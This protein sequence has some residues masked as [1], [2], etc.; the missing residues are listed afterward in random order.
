MSG[1]PSLLTAGEMKAVK[2]EKL[3]IWCAHMEHEY[4]SGGGGCE[5]CGYGGEGQSE[6][7]CAKGHWNE[8]IGS[9]SARN[10]R[11]Y[12][13]KILRALTCKD[14]KLMQLDA[15]PKTSESR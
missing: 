4:S 7:V 8:D 13:V 10:L 2:A 6:M 15:S 9:Y 1:K 11:D 3:C 14:Y 5:T 12:R